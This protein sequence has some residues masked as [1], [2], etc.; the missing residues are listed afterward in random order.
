[1]LA[2]TANVA[3][4]LRRCGASLV[5]YFFQ[6]FENRGYNQVAD[7]MFYGSLPSTMGKE[8]YGFVIDILS[9]WTLVSIC[10][11]GWKVTGCLGK[12]GLTKSIHRST[13]YPVIMRLAL[14]SS[15]CAGRRVSMNQILH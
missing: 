1:M 3:Y 15:H 4:H 14:C 7:G 2:G 11:S 12:N 13:Y 6:A 10:W 8:A 5:V 9:E